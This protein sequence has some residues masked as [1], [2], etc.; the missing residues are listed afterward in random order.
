MPL[1]HDDMLADRPHVPTWTDWFKAAGVNRPDV[2]RGLRFNSADHALQAA[3]EGAGVLL[4]QY[5]LA[6]DDL[7]SG[8][9]VIPVKF[10]LSTGRAYH[11]VCPKSRSE[12]PHVQA[13]RTWIKQEVAAIDW[14]LCRQGD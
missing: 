10:M 11:F 14:T 6:Y 7:R 12:Y 5:V 9:L 13:F 1:I 3:S 2:S 4:S 8:R